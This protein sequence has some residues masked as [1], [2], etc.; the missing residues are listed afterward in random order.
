LAAAVALRR[1]RRLAAWAATSALL[2]ATSGCPQPGDL[3]DPEAYCKPGASIVD[4][5]GKVVGCNGQASSGGGMAAGGCDTAC[6]N[7]LFANTCTSCHTSSA[8]LGGLDLQ[9]AGVAARLK[10]QAAKHQ[11]V[12]NPAQC[13]SGDKLVD[14]ASPTESWLLKKVNGQQGSCGTQMPPGNMPVSQAE[15]ACL[16]A[17]VSCVGGGT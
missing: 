14:S 2:L 5:R 17:Y 1:L 8:P 11:S 12:D 13:P 15:L 9:S 4:A 7:E 3:E 6:I 16:T 10:D